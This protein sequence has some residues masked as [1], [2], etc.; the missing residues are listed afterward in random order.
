MTLSSTLS[1]PRRRSLSLSRPSALALCLSIAFALCL[2][3][4]LT[5]GLVYPDILLHEEEITFYAATTDYYHLYY[6]LPADLLKVVAGY[7]ASWYGEVWRGVMIQT[8]AVLVVALVG[9]WV[10]RRLSR[11]RWWMVLGFVPAM[12]MAVGQ[13]HNTTV[14]YTICWVAAALVA[15]G[16]IGLIGLIRL[17]SQR[18]S[19]R[20]IGPIRPIRPKPSLWAIG[21]IGL[22]GLIATLTGMLRNPTARHYQWMQQLE[23]RAFAYDWEG[24]LEMVPEGYEGITEVSL[25]YFLLALAQTGQLGE[26]LFDFPVSKPGDFFLE[27]KNPVAFRFNSLFFWCL[28]VPNE[29]IRYAFQESQKGETGLAFGPLRRLVDWNLQR[30]DRRQAAY[31]MRLLAQTPQH[32]TFLRTRRLFLNQAP[33]SEPRRHV[34]LITNDL[35]VNASYV[36]E[37]DPG[38]R[39]ALDYLVCCFLL[40]GDY[41]SAADALAAYWPADEPLPRAYRALMAR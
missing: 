8:L 7:V 30:G 38:N 16:A 1:L 17:I 18:R 20:P 24:V 29:A 22:I 28:G 21:L 3:V 12:V 15:G 26:R 5:W 40:E 33:K 39:R 23:H 13:T 41:E 32:D 37:L 6:S 36:L 11:G 31:Y 34:F 14:Y 2:S 35:R 9:L 25:R 19:I 27:D 4:S 10:A